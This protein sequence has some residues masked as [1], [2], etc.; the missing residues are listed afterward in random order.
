M[1][2]ALEIAALGVGRRGQSPTRFAH[3]RQLEAQRIELPAHVVPT[4]L[5]VDRPPANHPMLSV[6][7]GAASSA[8]H[9]AGTGGQAPMDR[10]G[11]TVAAMASTS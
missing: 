5:Q 4:I 9:R 6:T 1:Q 11:A 3:L 8:D 10:L 7:A 2:I